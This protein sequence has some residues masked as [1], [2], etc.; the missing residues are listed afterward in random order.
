MEYAGVSQLLGVDLGDSFTLSQ[1][2]VRPGVDQ[3]LIKRLLPKDLSDS[4]SDTDLHTALADSLYAGYIEKHKIAA[5][6]VNHHDLLKVPQ[7]FDFSAIGG[8]ATEMVERLERADPKN[9]G[10]VRTIPGLTP[11][12]ISTVLVS[13]TA[14]QARSRNN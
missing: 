10:Q 9:F 11:V 7:N 12:A 5:E 2:S 1:L 6:R 14:E 3:D 4:V 8:L 13:L